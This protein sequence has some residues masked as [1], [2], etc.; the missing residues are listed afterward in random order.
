[1]TRPDIK[2]AHQNWREHWISSPGYRPNFLG[3][4]DF[5]LRW[6]KKY[7]PVNIKKENSLFELEVA[8]PGYSKEEIEISVKNNLLIIRGAKKKNE[9]HES[10]Y[11]IKEFDNDTFERVFQLAKEIGHEK[12]TATYKNG[13]LRL[14][15]I[16]VPGEE[17]VAY[18]KV[19]VL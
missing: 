12:I 14:T 13:I 10:E 2:T 9:L 17:E 3:R 1:M 15:F 18:K 19:A 16:D 6:L 7:P 4:N 8:I 11:V 5:D